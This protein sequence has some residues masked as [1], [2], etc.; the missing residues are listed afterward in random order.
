MIPAK[1]TPH[2]ERLKIALWHCAERVELRPDHIMEQGAR[3]AGLHN[4]EP[5]GPPIC[6]PRPRPLLGEALSASAS[7]CTPIPTTRPAPLCPL[8]RRNS[9]K[10]LATG[11]CR[12]HCSQSRARERERDSVCVYW[13]LGFVAPLAFPNLPPGRSGL[14][15]G[16][17][18][19]GA[20]CV[21]SPKGQ[22]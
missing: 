19:S 2:R 5:R 12:S 14:W 21:H 6:I 17:I 3:W 1:V 15:P 22:G 16:L 10:M 13:T 11:Y 18:N 8:F 20:C 7:V 4:T 9:P